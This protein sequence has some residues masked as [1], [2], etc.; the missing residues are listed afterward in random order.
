MTD[1]FD[2]KRKAWKKLNAAEARC[3]FAPNKWRLNSKGF[4]FF[5]LWKASTYGMTLKEIKADE[6]MIDFFAQNICHFIA[7]IFNISTSSTH[8]FSQWNLITP[9]PRR[10]LQQNFAVRCAK[11]ISEL[12]GIEFFPET[13]KAN[14]RLRVMAKFDILNIPP[15]LNIIC[16]DDIVTTGST[17][18][19]MNRC[20][21]GLGKN[22]IYIAGINN[23]L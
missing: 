3:D 2:R 4:F 16:F 18:Q 14:S 5:S 9:P 13:A 19:A 11:R 1:I 12:S 15:A 22:I 21:E 6:D 20:M 23:Q 17:F 8:D 10:H 7:K